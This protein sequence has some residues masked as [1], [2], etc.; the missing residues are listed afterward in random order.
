MRSYSYCQKSWKNTKQTTTKM[1]SNRISALCVGLVPG[2]RMRACRRERSKVRPV[3][4]GR[5][6]LRQKEYYLSASQARPM[7]TTVVVRS[8]LASVTHD[9]TRVKLSCFQGV[10]IGHITDDRQTQG[11]R[12]CATGQQREGP[13]EATQVGGS[14]ERRFDVVHSQHD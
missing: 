3:P 11:R 12:R 5:T 14:C 8:G 6:I 7:L 9:E 10:G 1:G 4:G 13:K 2:L